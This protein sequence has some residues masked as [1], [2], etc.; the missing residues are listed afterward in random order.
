MKLDIKYTLNARGF[1]DTINREKTFL[2]LF[3]RIYSLSQFSFNVRCA[4]SRY[5][6]TFP[7]KKTI[8]LLYSI[9]FPKLFSLSLSNKHR[10]ILS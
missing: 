4:A 6:S 2:L 10:K 5:N 1:F 3:E 8:K 9:L 7:Q